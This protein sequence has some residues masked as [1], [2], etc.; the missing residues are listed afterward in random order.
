[1]SCV[2]ALAI[3]GCAGGGSTMPPPTC[4]TPFILR[5]D[6]VLAYPAPGAT[7]VP[8]SSLTIEILNGGAYPVVLDDGHGV[9]IAAGTLSPTTNPPPVTIVPGAW[10]V[11]APQLAAHTTYTVDVI[12]PQSSTGC[13]TPAPLPPATF[14]LGSFTTQ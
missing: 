9:H 1:M 14:A 11:T 7:G 6:P 10:Y 12:V 13:G 2:A 8:A 4:V 5:A 3:A